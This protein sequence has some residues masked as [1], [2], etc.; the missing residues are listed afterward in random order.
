MRKLPVSLACWSSIV[1]KICFLPPVKIC[2]PVL[3]YRIYATEYY[4]EQ[5]ANISLLLWSDSLSEMLIVDRD[6]PTKELMIIQLTFYAV[7]PIT[8]Q[9]KFK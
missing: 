8:A 2:Q 6:D 1:R 9:Y 7:G 3:T 5:T 4:S